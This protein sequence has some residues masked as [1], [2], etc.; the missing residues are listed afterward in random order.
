MASIRDLKRVRKQLDD[1]C[2][3]MDNVKL[4]IMTARVR[5]KKESANTQEVLQTLDDA[6]SKTGGQN[7]IA[8]N[9]ISAEIA[10][11]EKEKN[12]PTE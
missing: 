5:A 9:Y 2:D 4:S 7:E 1:I 6:I 10:R 12:D 3:G 11:L 8:L